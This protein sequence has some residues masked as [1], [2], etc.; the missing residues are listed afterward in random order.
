[1]DVIHPRW[2]IDPQRHRWVVAE[3]LGRVPV[4]DGPGFSR[5]GIVWWVAQTPTWRR[6]PSSACGQRP[7]RRRRTP[8]PDRDQRKPVPG[9]RSRP[10]APSNHCHPGARS[11]TA[12]EADQPV[13][14]ATGGKHSIAARPAPMRSVGAH[15]NAHRGPVHHQRQPVGEL[16]VEIGRRGKRAAG[17]NE[18]SR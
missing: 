17:G 7:A 1:M 11:E 14:G 15:P 3:P 8:G 18:R 13:A 10:D 16:G 4:L 2:A 9:A 12:V 5:S 6:T